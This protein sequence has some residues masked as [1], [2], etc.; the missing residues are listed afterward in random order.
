[1][2]NAENEGEMPLPLHNNQVGVEN[3]VI[4]NMESDRVLALFKFGK[5]EHIDQFVHEGHI[6]MNPLNYFKTLENDLLRTDKHEGASYNLQADGAKL[7]V[8]LN[9][10]WVDI[11]RIKEQMVWS[12]GSKHITKVFCMYALL[13]ST[14]KNLVDPR[15]FDFG[16]TF[17]VLKDGDEFL[18]RVHAT[19]KKE[20]I[21]LKQGF[22]E[23][24]NKATYDGAMG[25]FRK[26]SE[27][28]YQSEFR[29]SVIT[30]KET[31]FSLRIGNISDISM[32]GPLAE[33]NKRI[34]ISPK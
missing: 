18:R 15:N 3:R 21:V 19:A 32:I 20:N 28:A 4:Q 23:Y 22:V 13:G 14:S 17:V 6:Y 11:A 30:E 8:E 25:V 5:R 10:K 2:S 16:D 1:M 27:F 9:G 31:P 26:F 7:L 12:D 33:L 29:L 34:K 24:V